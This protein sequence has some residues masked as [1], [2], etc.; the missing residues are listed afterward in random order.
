MLPDQFSQSKH[1]DRRLSDQHIVRRLRSPLRAQ[2]T[3]R[4]TARANGEIRVF[5][6]LRLL[7]TG[8]RARRH[9]PDLRSTRT[10]EADGLLAEL[11]RPL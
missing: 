1:L 10:R 8:R 3:P 11:D 6:H 7:T 5:A 9:R 2:E 4:R